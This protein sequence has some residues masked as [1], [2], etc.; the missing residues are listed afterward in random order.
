MVMERRGSSSTR[1]ALL[2]AANRVVVEEGVSGMTLEAVAREAGVSKGGLLYHFPSKEALV[3][4]M[5]G[6]LIEGFGEALGRE[7]RK[8][9]GGASGRWSRAYLRASFTEDRWYLRVSA[10]LLAA[11]AEDPALL[12]PLRKGYEDGQRWAERDGID[13]AVATLVRLAADG[14]FF[15]E[16]LGLAPPEGALRRR[17]LETSLSLTERSRR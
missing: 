12:D 8:E 17:V 13:P 6:G 1:E 5:I 4:A 11:V 14:L 16:L 2:R 9:K 3:E 10:G 15:A 7:L